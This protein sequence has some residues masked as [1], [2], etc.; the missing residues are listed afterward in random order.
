MFT[1]AIIV[2]LFLAMILLIQA[3]RDV[4]KKKRPAYLIVLLLLFPLVGPLL[5]FQMSRFIVS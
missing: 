3:I 5:Y 4:I 1:S 2:L